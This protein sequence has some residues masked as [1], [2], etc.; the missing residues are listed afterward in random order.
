MKPIDLAGCVIV[1]EHNRML[2]LHR[3]DDVTGL[4]G[5]WEM[6]GGKLEPGEAAEAAAMRELYEELGIRVQLT[7]HLGSE[8]FEQRDRPY[9]Y[10]WFRATIVGGQPTIMETE[11]YD[12]VDYFELQ[13]IPSLALSLNMHNLLNK[14]VNG[15]IHL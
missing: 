11:A 14:L 5:Q 1:D 2:L 9:L 12:D 3:T 4:E 10:Q 8:V 7:E 6:P 15:E 13:D